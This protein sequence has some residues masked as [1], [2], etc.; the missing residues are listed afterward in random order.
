MTQDSH[1]LTSKKPSRF[2]D[3]SP[4]TIDY[5]VRYGNHLRAA[6]FAAYLSGFGSWIARLVGAEAKPRPSIDT[7]ADRFANG[8]AAIR[9][10][11]E[12]LRDTPDLND[13]ERARFVA[14]VLEEERRLAGVLEALPNLAA[15]PLAAR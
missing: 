3:I 10:S 13:A 12:I 1:R 8:L 9:S 5:Y 6:T 2:D 14:I 11:A 7:V 4:E 15:Q